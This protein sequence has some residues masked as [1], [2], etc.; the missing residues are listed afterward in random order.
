MSGRRG[1][2]PRDRVAAPA[3]AVNLLRTTAREHGRQPPELRWRVSRSGAALTSGSYSY[4]ENRISILEG[5][6][7]AAA[8]LT[9]CHE[10][11]HWLTGEG[12]NS[13]AF[14]LK[15]WELYRRWRVPVGYALRSETRYRHRAFRA[16]WAGRDPR[17]RNPAGRV[18]F[19][20]ASKVWQRRYRDAWRGTADWVNG[21]P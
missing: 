18:T 13:D 21:G 3:W 16:Y 5:R 12:H 9:L 1:S 8:R 15:A 6:L 17:G 10:I 20:T 4:D 19:N 14:W 7:R 11:A 2:G